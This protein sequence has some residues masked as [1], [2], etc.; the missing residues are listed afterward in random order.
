M[1]DNIL[2]LAILF[3]VIFDPPLSFTVF[4]AYAANLPQ[5]EKYRMALAALLVAAMLSL[6]VLVFGQRI[7]S[8][9]SINIDDFR[10]AGGIILAMLGVK[11]VWGQEIVPLSK[12]GDSGRA[13]SAI[14]GTPL[15]AGPAA[16]TAIILS[17]QDF[18]MTATGAAIT[19][20]LAITAILFFVAANL[21]QL[22][23]TTAIQVLSTL[24]G[25]ITLA[26]GINFIRMGFGF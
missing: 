13:I 24:M 21:N 1:W 20:V 16:I 25:L 12:K 10:I 15:L 4:F 23:G 18:G 3:F 9:F 5:K 22:K 26:W 19:I 17:A 14:I 11:M 2:Q 6:V 7:L 8:A